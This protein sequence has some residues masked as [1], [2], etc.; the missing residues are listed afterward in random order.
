[1]YKMS[2]IIPMIKEIKFRTGCSGYYNRHW[3]TIFYPEKLPQQQWFNFYAGQLNTVELN[4]TFYRF[5][6]A[7]KLNEWYKKSPAEFLFS[8]K[9]P[10]L[11]THLKK[12]NDCQ[13]QVNEFYLACKDGLI[14]K[15]G[16]VLF[17]LPPSVHYSKEKLEQI[18]SSLQSEFRN[19]I[20]F[21]HE[22]WWRK[23]VYKTLAESH[24]TFCSVSHPSMPEEI[25]VNTSTAYVRL[26]GVPRMFYSGYSENELKAM[27]DT[28]M[29]KKGLKECFVYFNNTAG[30]E[31]INNALQ[32]QKLAKSE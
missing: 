6:T 24:I 12:F 23:D 31:G 20:E 11:I 14:E 7:E 8:V 29:K 32:F 19:V 30:D 26:H 4:T 22:S 3:K 17:Q 10:R 27:Y 13:Q 5:P 9:A 16:C 15:L 21:R 25:V 28:L 1:M 2:E 18:I